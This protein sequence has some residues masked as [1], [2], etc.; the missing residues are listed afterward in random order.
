[1][2]CCRKEKKPPAQKGDKAI[3]GTLCVCQALAVL[4][5][6]SIIYLSVIIY[7]PAK[8]ELESGIGETPVM[9]QT[10]QS[11]H[12]D[13]DIELC[14]STSCAEWCLSK[15]GG[16]CDQLFVSVRQNGTDVNFEDCGEVFEKNC[17]K[18]ES[19]DEL[20]SNCK[21]DQECTELTGVFN[22][23]LGVCRNITSVYTCT[24]APEERE[25]QLNCFYKRNC[26]EL[27][28]MY[29][30]RDG[31]CSR[32]TNWDCD[33]R[34]YGI[35]TLGR[36][37]L[38]MAGDHIVSAHCRSA[39]NRRTGEVIWKAE[40][41]PGT[42]LMASCTTIHYHEDSEVLFTADC[43]NG[44]RLPFHLFPSPTTRFTQLMDVFH[45][46]GD[47]YKLDM[48]DRVSGLPRGTHMPFDQDIMIY[49]RTMLFINH[50]GC[51]NTLQSECNKFYE[52]HGKDGRNRSSPSRFPCFY[53]ADNQAFVVRRYDLVQTKVTF[54]MFFTVPAAIFVT[55]CLILFICS[56]VVGVRREGTMRLKNCCK[57]KKDPPMQM[58]ILKND[59]LEDLE[60]EDE[61]V[62]DEDAV[63]K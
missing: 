58:K 17:P 30:C 1:M 47:Q 23:E 15:G 59:V 46:H 29:D 13:N 26:V 18:Y 48:P 35:P 36:N 52:E 16:S 9:C 7:L 6:V 60:E 12:I 28:G 20:L 10:S 42:I 2:G 57:K 61:D 45:G 53:A 41:H 5:T 49:N 62:D 55:S 34:C 24:W 37:I 8:R 56:N 40:S 21:K 19:T 11:R 39:V 31:M 4:S 50:E 51:V 63:F 32:L 44:T 14:K 38:A 43:V 33:R 25:E 22:C 54:L 27:D 3:C